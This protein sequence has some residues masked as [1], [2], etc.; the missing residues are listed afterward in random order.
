VTERNLGRFGDA[1][2]RFRRA[3]AL[4][5]PWVH[6]E[7]RPVGL[8]LWNPAMTED[9]LIEALQARLG[10]RDVPAPAAPDAI[11]ETEA[12]C[13][14]PL[15][16]LLTRVLTEVANG[17]VGPR[18][19]LYGVRGHDWYSSDIFADMTE[20]AQA[21]AEDEEW[22]RRRWALPL[23]DWGCAIMTL[24]D[25]RDPAGP[26]WG[27]D[28]N[29]CCLDHALFPL[30][31]TLGAMLEESLAGDYPEPFYTGYGAG[32]RASEPGCVPVLWESGRVKPA[33]AP[34]AG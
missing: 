6:G 2:V 3:A 22:G 17:G 12:A 10:D 27:W 25:C 33:V 11:A 31:Q 19:S 24:V 15:P 4:P 1:A 32:L 7:D 18:E 21:S 14:Y 5:L 30:D 26:L 9:E 13:G 34:P 28:P 16:P 8:D 29:L 20:A 23:I